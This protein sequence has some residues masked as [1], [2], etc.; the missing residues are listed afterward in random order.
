VSES[1]IETS[2]ED[3]A[4]KVRG[5][6]L[7]A[8][9]PLVRRHEERLF[10][11][12]RSKTSDSR[13]AEDLTQKVFVSAFQKISSYDPERKFETW[14][15]AIARNAAIDHYRHTARRPSLYVGAET[16]PEGVDHRDPAMALAGAE[17]KQ[18]LWGNIRE[19]L[20]DTQ[21]RVLW[22]RYEEDLP[23]AEIAATMRKTSNNIK[24][25]LHRA[26]ERLAAEWRSSGVTP[27]VP[28]SGGVGAVLN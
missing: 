28:D 5:G 15:Y 17:E 11:F 14:L 13:D 25:L 26:R 4:R 22:L 24:V 6:D 27:F 1:D 21:F 9:D 20:N 3:L 19:Q 8:Y 10:H 12:M 7:Q 16:P 18:A 2:D 23:V